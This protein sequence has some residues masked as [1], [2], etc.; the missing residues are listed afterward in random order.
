MAE[1]LWG[2]IYFHDAYAGMLQQLPGGRC[3]FTYDASYIASGRPPI[4]WTLPV[5]APAHVSELG[6]HPFFDNLVAEGW[7]EQAQSRLLG[8]R[9]HAP[10]TV[11]GFRP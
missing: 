4:A 10:R 1:L 3:G 11:A 6:L 7:L 2:Q 5:R 9:G 8:K